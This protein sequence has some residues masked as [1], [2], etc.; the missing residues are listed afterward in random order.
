MERIDWT[1]EAEITGNS[2]RLPAGGYIC[3]ITNVEDYPNKQYLKLEYEIVDGEYKGWG[4]KTAGGGWWRLSFIRSYKQTA[5]GYFKHFL[6]SLEKS[7]PGKFTVANFGQDENI[8]RGLFIGLIVGYE[9]YINNNDELKE[10]LYVVDT[11]AGQDIRN[12]NYTVPELKKLKQDAPRFD[13]AP[14]ATNDNASF[15]DDDQ[16]PF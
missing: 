9:E 10:R 12:G 3:K 13:A 5:R 14:A 16:L 4:E 11:V 8:L 6:S 2:E 7:N 1:K 15:I